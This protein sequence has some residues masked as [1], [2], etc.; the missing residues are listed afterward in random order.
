V[1]SPSGWRPG[2]T[3]SFSA[4]D[5]GSGLATL[6]YSEDGAQRR[7]PTVVHGDQATVRISTDGV[8]TLTITATDRV[9][10]TASEPVV[11]QVDTQAP[12]VVCGTS[13]GNWHA[14]NVTIP[15]TATDTQSGLA[16]PGQSTF[17]LQ[18][19]VPAGTETAD[20]STNSL[21]VCDQLGNCATAGPV[22]GIMVDEAPPVITL[23][24]PQQDAV[25]EVGQQATAGYTCTDGGS[26]VASC[27][28][29][30]ADGAPLDT[31][32]T[33]TFSFTVDATDNVGNSTSTTVSY[34][35]IV[36]I[37]NVVPPGPGQGPVELFVVQPCNGQPP[38]T[39]MHVVGVDQSLPATPFFPDPSNDFFVVPL[40][41]TQIYALS[42]RGL[43]PG[44]HTLDVTVA[45]D[46]VVHHL[47]FTLTAPDRS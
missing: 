31:S 7:A 19:D 24:A 25:Y 30:V 37:C 14:T 29:T 8:T 17:A 35:V 20:A 1:A 5:Q 28:G 34:D 16:D 43:A 18:T 11:V 15:C 23:S 13:D 41:E 9:G 32:T 33:G 26:G 21:V 6:S 44:Q 40:T 3:V 22:T 39:P 12:T 10:N 47:A 45:G 36:G 46:P 27:S 38:T 42:T 4:V 2:A